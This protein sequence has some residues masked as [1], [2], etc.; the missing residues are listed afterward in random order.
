MLLEHRR[1]FLLF[2]LKF[3]IRFRAA[4]GVDYFLDWEW[5]WRVLYDVLNCLEIFNLAEVVPCAPSL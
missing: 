3:L 5:H 1:V 4:R 2:S